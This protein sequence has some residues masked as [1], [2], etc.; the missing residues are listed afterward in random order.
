MDDQQNAAYYK[1]LINQAGSYHE[2]V[3][4]RS[5][6]FGLMER[7]LSKEDCLEVKDLWAA[8][9]GDE[10]LPVAPQKSGQNSE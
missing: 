1:R 4:L 6:F 2:L 9:A 5:R 10:N 7:A 8:K 3:I